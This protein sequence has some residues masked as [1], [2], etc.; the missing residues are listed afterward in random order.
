MQQSNVHNNVD[1]ITLTHVGQLSII[2][3]KLAL[4]SNWHEYF[5]YYYSTTKQQVNVYEDNS[6]SRTF[7]YI[8]NVQISAC[9]LNSSL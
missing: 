8:V 3:N 2:L 6:P 4:P 9:Q 1:H 7:T 5:L